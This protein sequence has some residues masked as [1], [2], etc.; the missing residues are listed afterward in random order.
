MKPKP[1]CDPNHQSNGTA[2]GGVKPKQHAKNKKKNQKNSEGVESGVDHMTNSNKNF[3]NGS[4]VAHNKNHNI[5]NDQSIIKLNN[6]KNCQQN[7]HLKRCQ[8]Q[9]IA[10]GM[11]GDR[12]NMKNHN[13]QQGKKNNNMKSHKNEKKIVERKENKQQINKIRR[14][15]KKPTTVHS[16]TVDDDSTTFRSNFAGN[17]DENFASE[18]IGSEEDDYEDGG[19]GISKSH[20]SNFVNNNDAYYEDNN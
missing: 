20:T 19:F 15:K 9:N 16:T 17:Y 4:I 7:P 10:A 11:K 8:Q 5:N 6:K 2:G 12:K 3:P 13:N 14:R 18:E 1:K